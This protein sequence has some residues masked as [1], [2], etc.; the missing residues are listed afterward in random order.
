M[1]ASLLVAGIHNAGYIYPEIRRL[2]AAIVLGASLG[3]FFFYARFLLCRMVHRLEANNC[4]LLVAVE[5]KMDNLSKEL[6]ARSNKMEAQ[7]NYKIAMID[8]NTAELERLA[9]VTIDLEQEL[10]LLSQRIP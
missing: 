6:A 4:D 8:K 2:W 7:M 5:M 10:K 9:K 1:I 3:C